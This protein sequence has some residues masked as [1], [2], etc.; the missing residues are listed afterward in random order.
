MQKL[1]SSENFHIFAKLVLKAIYN[2]QMEYI[3]I[4]YVFG[5][6]T[7]FFGMMAIFFWRRGELLY[8]LVALLTGTISIECVKDFIIVNMGLYADSRVWDTMTAIDMIAVPM[9]AFVLT[10]LVRPGSLTVKSMIVQELP[11][12]IL[13]ILYITLGI[14]W[15]FYIEVGY[16]AVYGTGVLVWTA[17]NI[18]RY[19]RHL[20]ELYSYTENVNLNW[21]KVILYTFYAILGVWI[22][23]CIVIHLDME[24]FYLL[25]NLVMWM[26]ISYFLYRHESV[27]E[28]LPDWKPESIVQTAD[29]NT[30]AVKINQLFTIDK[31]YLKPNLKLS[32]IATAVGSNRTYVS[33]FFNREGSGNFY[34][35]V[36]NHRI[37]HACHLLSDSNLPIQE[38]AQESGFSSPSVFSRVFS[39]YKG[40]SPT[41]FRR[42]ST[43]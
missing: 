26:V 20:K 25:C 24:C 30:I 41:E 27:I 42:C 37:S 5:L 31:I 6:A 11:F 17:V 9:Y 36:N 3:G 33:N 21:L 29:Y 16:A 38:V 10:E 7:M 13:P 32:D 28:E 12:V 8:R 19:N 35:Y 34:E 4:S 2:N 22:F 1:E 15:I 39:K 18:P 40:C 23:D 14:S 43:H